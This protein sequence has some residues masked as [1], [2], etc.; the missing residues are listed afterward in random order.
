MNKKNI[1]LWALYDFANSIA[2]IVF[3]L[4]FSQWLIIEKGVADIWYNLIFVC[5]TALLLFTAPVLGNIADKVGVR[6]PYLIILTMLQF[7]ALLGVCILAVFVPSSVT[8]VTL[9]AVLFLLANY[10]YQFQFVFYTPLLKE[11]ALEKRLGFVSGLGQ[12]FNWLGQIV[13]LLITLPLAAGSIIFMGSSLRAQTFLPATLIF[14]VLSLP[15][16]IL[17]KESNKPKEIKINLGSEY[18]D[19][20]KNFK[21]LIKNPGL[22]KFLLGYFFFNDAMITATNNFPIYLQQVFKVDDKTKSYLLMGILLTSAI[23]AFLTGWVSDKIGLKKAL[24]LILGSWIVIFPSMASITVF[25]YFIAIS[26]ILGFMFGAT[27]AVTRAVMVYLTPYERLN[28]GFSYY[29]MAERCST[30]VGPL[31]WGLITS[32]L[33]STGEL[34]YRVAMASMVVFVLIGLIIVESIPAKARK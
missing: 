34:R 9:A 19:Y 30:L 26:I 17:F 20:L 33:V 3:F 10:F 22:G 7:L 4:Y 11:I 1:F 13:G 14:F 28:H 16:L 29:T 12:S 27:W 25:N 6:M 8:S 15:M 21:S 32:L 18:K 5:S 31:A 2:V 23:G 24:M